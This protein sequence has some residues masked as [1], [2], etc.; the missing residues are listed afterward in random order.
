MGYYNLSEKIVTGYQ[1]LRKVSGLLCVIMGAALVGA[2]GLAIL[3]PAQL[4]EELTT[5]PKGGLLI[6]RLFTS[7]S[8][9]LL[10]SVLIY[11]PYCNRLLSIWDTVTPTLPEY[12]TTPNTTFFISGRTLPFGGFL[13]A[14]FGVAILCGDLST[15]T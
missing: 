10:S 11:P 5:P 12:L 13:L 7:G 4:L 9:F 15:V 2:G 8:L 3:I 14:Q 6:A 1:W